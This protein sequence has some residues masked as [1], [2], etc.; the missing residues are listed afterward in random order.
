MNWELPCEIINEG[1]YY[2]VLIFGDVVA[3]IPRNRPGKRKFQEMANEQNLL[4]QE[5]KGVLPCKARDKYLLMPKAKGIR[6][7]KLNYKEGKIAKAREALFKRIEAAGW[8]AGDK[9]PKNMFWDEE[10][11]ELT[12]VDFHLLKR[13]KR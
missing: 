5:V 12:M 4:S 3:K 8:D 7:D 10:T 2:I 11:G 13:R 9:N 6:T 1:A